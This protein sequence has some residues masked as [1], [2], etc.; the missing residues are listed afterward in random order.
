MLDFPPLEGKRMKIGWD[1][2]VGAAILIGALGLRAVDPL[3]LQ[4]LR[5]LTFDSYQRL[6]PR[7]YDPSIPVVIA[8]ID[9][10]SLDK[11][12]QWP[13]SR[14]TLAQITDRLTELGAAAIAF[15]IIFA[16]PDR[17]SPI[18]IASNLPADPQYDAARAQLAALPD[19]DADFAAALARSPSVLAFA[20]SGDAALSADPSIEFPYGFSIIG[21]AEENYVAGKVQGAPFAI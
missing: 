18:A 3:P 20:F 8:T 1:L 11:F 14:T 19:P 9:E 13:W 7:A 10:K 17:T 2:A 12:G 15:D 6:K 4:T 5:N 21:T 16:E